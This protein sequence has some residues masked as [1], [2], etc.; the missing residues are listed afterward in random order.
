MNHSQLFLQLLPEAVLV[1][2]AL[3]MLGA[4]VATGRKPGKEFSAGIGIATFGLL[5]AAA[6]MFFV[7]PAGESSTPLLA[8]DTLARIFK[9]VVLALGLFAIWLPL[10]RK[11]LE[12]PGEYYALALFAL[13]GLMLAVGSNHLLFLFVALELSSLSLYLLAG[14]PRTARASEASL[15]YFLFGGL[16]AAFMLF[17]ISL[18]YGVSHSATLSGIAQALE[19]G[20]P[21]LLAMT[22]LAMLLVGLGFKLAAVP[23][24]YWAPDVYQGAPATTVAIVSAASKAVGLVVLVRILQIGFANVAGSAAWGEMTA[25]W[26]LWLAVLAAVSMIAG[27]VLALAQTSVRRLLAYSAIAN[28]GYLLVALSANGPK[29]AAAALFYVVVYGLA[30]LGALAVT[31][32]VERDRGDDRISSFAGLIHRSPFQAVCLLV[33]LTSLAGI[34][35]LAGFVGKFALFSDALA[36]GGGMGFVWLVG[37]AAVLSAVSLYYYLSVLK[38]V[39][40]KPAPEDGFQTRTLPPTHVLNLAIPALLLVLLG[41]LPSL[42]LDPIARALCETLR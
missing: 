6:A 37:L 23:F 36:E 3:V 15:K 12:N 41:T 34:P 38:Q 14:F 8:N 2:T 4:A 10:A 40:V 26:S 11:E 21:S 28:T 39:F 7:P 19:A 29:A 24:H 18:L 17:G 35:P 25:G 31:A 16:S 33:F 20:Q 13:T 9:V 32:A 5:L 22:G 30:T 27:N 42:L 1:L